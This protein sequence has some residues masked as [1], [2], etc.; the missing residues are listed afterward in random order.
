MDL[1]NSISNIPILSR[2]YALYRRAAL[3]ITLAGLL[4]LAGLAARDFLAAT[5]SYGVGVRTDSVAYLWGAEN[6]AKGLGLGR[7]NGLGELKPMTHW[8]PFYPLVLA[9]F[10]LAGIPALEG[11]RILGAALVALILILHLLCWRWPPACGSPAWTR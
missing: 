5:E 11:A 8:P 9:V 10:E 3:A 4:A 7:L 1:R 6:L 2:L